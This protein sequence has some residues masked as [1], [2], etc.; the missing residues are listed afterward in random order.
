MISPLLTLLV[1]AEGESALP[2]I[3]GLSVE[4]VVRL[5]LRRSARVGRGA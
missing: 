4:F 3:T 1:S 2:D 5:A